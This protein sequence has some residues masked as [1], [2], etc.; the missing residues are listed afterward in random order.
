LSKKQ[1]IIHSYAVPVDVPQHCDHCKLPAIYTVCIVGS[2]EGMKLESQKVSK[3]YMQHYYDAQD[4]DRYTILHEAVDCG[5]HLCGYYAQT[6]GEDIAIGLV[7]EAERL[8]RSIVIGRRRGKLD[9]SITQCASKTLSAIVDELE[10][11]MSRGEW[12]E[13]KV[14]DH[15]RID[16]LPKR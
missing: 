14:L 9:L 11:R 13:G 7:K 6:V 4:N 10:K 2:D 5:G 3:R 8:G 16:D 12:S 1:F 15:A